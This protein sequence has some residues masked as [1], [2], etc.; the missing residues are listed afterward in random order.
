[1]SHQTINLLLAGSLENEAL[2]K[3]ALNRYTDFYIQRIERKKE[4][5]EALQCRQ[6]QIIIC[7]LELA[8]FNALEVPQLIQAESAQTTDT[9][10]ALML[11][12]G[13]GDENIALQCLD[14]GICQFIQLHDKFL[15]RL[16]A[17]ID[18]SLIRLEKEQQRRLIEQE[19]TVS[20]E[21]YL[22][23]FENTN[24]LIQCL[25]PDGSFIYTN[26]AWRKVM[27][28]SRE[29]VKS[30]NLLDVLHP[31]SLVCCQERFERLN[32]GESL[33]CIAF[34]FI[35]KTGETVAL[36]GDC[37][38][39]VKEGEIISTRGIFRNV[40][41]KVQA[42]EA[43][44]LSELRYQALYENAPDIYT[45]INP[46]GEILSINRIGARLLGYAVEE[47]VGESAANVIHP[48]DQKTVFEFFENHFD[49]PMPDN[50]LEYRLVRKDD[51]ILWVHQ[52]ISLESGVS[53][54]RL[55]V[56]CRDV[57]EKRKLEEQLAHFATHDALTNLINRREF[58]RRLQ[59][60]LQSSY[61]SDETHV[62]CY[63]DLDQ[64]KII[65]D[66]SGHIAGDELLRQISTLLQEHM[67][68]RDTLA[69]IG[70]DEFVILMEY[71]P[72]AKAAQ[73]ADKIRKTIENFKFH[74]RSSCFS[75]GVS[76]GLM[77]IQDGHTINEALSLADAA[78]YLAKEKGR[79][80]IHIH[81]PE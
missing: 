46:A 10:T 16:P 5:Q 15:N 33:I 78:C 39:I 75:V 22:D 17:L 13:S 19:L 53:E 77:K 48:L 25:L 41:E 49:N 58:D 45:T 50:G 29:E 37:G 61:G 31:D 52:R 42:E 11:I 79:N 38:S 69:R 24:D 32:R 2:I 23:I 3:R 63:L 20:K 73:L 14:L 21:R 67:R 35:S 70:G 56:V 18:N 76:I 51:S 36:E 4:L 28:Y 44:R 8:D 34:N 47:L 54:P 60:L 6:W 68:S 9:E 64:F 59:R 27:G 66:S 72:L 1:M 62:L 81:K 12:D 57:T 55:M 80:C 65:N 40:T 7:E 30:L 26:N 71:C 74:W 43:L